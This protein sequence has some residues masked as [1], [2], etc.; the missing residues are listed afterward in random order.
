M[1]L[2][3]TIAQGNSAAK[4]AL[5]EGSELLKVSIEEHLSIDDVARFMAPATRVELVLYCCVAGRG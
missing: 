1:S 3:L 2:F 5:W 4:M